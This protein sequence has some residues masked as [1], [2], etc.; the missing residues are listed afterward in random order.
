M[1]D[2]GFYKMLIPF[3]KSHSKQSIRLVRHF[4]KDVHLA[5]QREKYR[6]AALKAW[7]T[8]RRKHKEQRIKGVEKL[9]RWIEV[10]NIDKITHPEIIEEKIKDEWVGNGVIK[11]FKKTP[12]DIACGP[13]WELRWAYGCP[14]NCSY[15]Y[16]RGTMRGRMKPSFVRIEEVKRCLNEAFHHISDPQIFNSGELCDSLMNPT[17]MAE[18]VDMFEEQNK[19][20]IYLLSKFGTKNIGFLLEKLRKQVICAW[21]INAEPVSRKWESNAAVPK[22]RIYAASLVW[23]MGYDTRIRIDPIF[24]IKNW[25]SHYEKLLNEIFSSLL[26]NRIVLGTPRGLWKTIN[27]AQKEGV[28][29]SWADFFEEN[30]GW[31][32]KLSFEVRKDIYTF[33]YDALISLNYPAHKISMCKETNNMWKELGIKNQL[34]MCNCYGFNAYH[35]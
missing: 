14:L 18:I 25:K 31:G 33:F 1:V 2:L 35:P 3:F 26:P 23:E 12:D 13:F 7:E 11:L 20:K 9:T 24:P 17:L 5:E 15:C 29:M 16:L 10:E 21:S 32:K 30:T 8:I 27:Y 19:H 22:D 34:K 28:D 4:H 6:K